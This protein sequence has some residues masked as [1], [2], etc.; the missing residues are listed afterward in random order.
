MRRLRKYARAFSFGGR[1]R[2]VSTIH[3]NGN[4]PTIAALPATFGD[5]TSLTEASL[6]DNRLATIPDTIGN[7]GRLAELCG[8]ELR[9][10]RLIA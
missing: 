8:A 9:G 10:Q 7:L 1:A 2:T 6:D 5:L 4:D 3:R